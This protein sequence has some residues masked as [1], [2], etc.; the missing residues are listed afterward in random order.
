MKVLPAGK[1]SCF[2]QFFG[3]LKFAGN[4]CNN[5]A[6]DGYH[7]ATDICNFEKKEL[8]FPTSGNLRI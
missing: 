4:G 7:F 8:S 6:T 5:F 2:H 3:G 1:L